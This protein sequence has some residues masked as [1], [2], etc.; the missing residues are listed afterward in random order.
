MKTI[1]ELK[2][3]Y[4]ITLLP[5]LTPFEEERKRIANK[6]FMAAGIIVPLAII[7]V[8]LAWGATHDSDLPVFILFGCGAI[9]YGIYYFLTKEYKSKF[10]GNVIDKIVN[11]IDPNLKYSKSAYVSEGA[12][13]SSEIFKRKPDRYRG[14]DFVEG[15]LGATKIEFSEIHAQYRTRD[16]KGRSHWHTIFKGLFFVAD[17]NKNFSGKTVVLP[18]VAEKLFGH[19]GT[20]MQSWNAARAEVIKLEDPEFEKLFAV[21]GDNQIE[22]RYILSTS[23]MQRIVEFKKKTKREIYLSF[24]GS[25]IFIAVSYRKNLFEPRVFRTLLDFTPIQEYFED[26]QLAVGIVQD[27]NL[28]TR[29]WSKQ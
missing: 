19:I 21:Y 1:E 5:Q 20:L 29:I 4:N 12:F 26:L 24:V 28:N 16:S 17:F 18:D 27:L 23:L 3:F 13:T 10:K 11:F 6:I 22:A 15:E 7:G 2:N 14:D 8:V 9:V 25:K